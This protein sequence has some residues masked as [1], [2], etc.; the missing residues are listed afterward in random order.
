MT[1]S[2][3]HNEWVN[4]DWVVYLM[5]R[6]LATVA[7]NYFSFQLDL[8][9]YTKFYIKKNMMSGMGYLSVHIHTNQMFEE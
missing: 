4:I 9:I 8:V 7:L 3:Q 5:I 2:S 6:V 1:Q